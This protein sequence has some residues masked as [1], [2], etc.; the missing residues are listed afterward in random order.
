MASKNRNYRI[1]WFN[2]KFAGFNFYNLIVIVSFISVLF[3][4]SVG[5]YLLK[6]EFVGIHD[7]NDAIYYTIVTYTTL[8]DGNIYP[9]TALGKYLVITMVILGFGNFAMFISVV[10]YQIVN[11]IQ[12]AI[13]RLQGEKIHM[14]NHVI[15]CGY[16][17]LTELLINKFQKNHTPF[18]LLDN[19]PHPELNSGENGNFFYVSV[20]NRL[21]SLYKANVEM[22]KM[23]IATSSLD[24]ENI[25]A[26]INA[27]R[28]R[29]EHNASFKIMAR[30]LYEENI[31]IAK[32]S[33]ADHVISPTMM[34][35]NAI[36][37]LM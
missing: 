2:K 21:E 36:I 28:L 31:E 26:V 13:H 14:K 6:K 11:H 33:G 7:F 1:N 3:Y 35:A 5:C 18:I 32:D 27:N 29:V 19:K 30:V 25:L 4:G 24:S 20:P 22:C 10:F 9:I 37:G 15:L 17:I 8:G 12:K 34:E 23:V 16:S